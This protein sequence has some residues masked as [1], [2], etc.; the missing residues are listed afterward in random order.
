MTLYRKDIEPAGADIRQ[1]SESS[2][3]NTHDSVCSNEI[4]PSMPQWLGQSINEQ[5]HALAL[6]A[7]N[8][9]LWDWNLETDEVHY[10]PRWK[11]MLGYAEDE[12]GNTISVWDELV[13]PEDKDRVLKHV[14]DY[15]S[16]KSES[17]DIEMRMMHKDGRVIDI[18]SRAYSALS[19]TSGKPTRLVGTH[20][21][22]T[23]RVK[24][25]SFSRRTVEILEMIALG[26]P[27]SEIYDAIGLMYEDRHPGLRCS[28][29]EL[30]NGVLLHGGAPSMPKEYCDAVHGLKNGPEVGSC[31]T[32]T[33]WG[34]RC[35]VENIETDPK[36]ADIKQYAL[37]HGMRSCWSEPI[38]NSNGVVLGAFGMY[39][40]YPALPNEDESDDLT[41]AARL[42]GIIMERDHHQ[43]QIHDLAFTDQLTGLASRAHFYNYLGD[44]ITTS[45]RHGRSFSLIYVDLDSFKDVNDSLGHDSGDTLLKIIADRLTDLGGEVD[46]ISRLSGDEFCIVAENVANTYVSA[47][48]AQQCIEVISQPAMVAGRML[49]STCSAGIS[50]F[51]ADGESTSSLIKA[52][53]TALYS[54][55]YAGKN[56]YA[57]YEP[58]LTELAE[59]RFKFEQFL[60]EAIDN[61][62]MSLVYQPQ[63]ETSTGEIIGVEALCRWNHP[64][65]GQVSP[66]EFIEAAERIGM[67]KPLTEW[68]LKT[69][70][71]QAV[72][73]KH[74]GLPD[75]RVAVNISPS[76]FLD[77]GLIALVERMIKE[78][79][80]D[81]SQLELEVTESV[82]QTDQENLSVFNELD[83]LGILIAIDDFGTGYSSFSSLK[84]IEV[85]YLKIDK[86]FIDDIVHDEK[87]KLLVASMI[88]IGHN[89]GHRIIAEGVEDSSQL[90]LLDEMGCD[91]IQGYLF[92][93]PIDAESLLNLLKSGVVELP[94][95]MVA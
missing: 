8:D 1:Q 10:S 82:V 20:V 68:V 11:S 7:A 21:D 63:V 83:N 14:E 91:T 84:H 73:W 29:L 85:D 18:W 67:I 54:A 48:I 62:Q 57:F 43:K 3:S 71:N 50:H 41:S 74:Q 59:Y 28:M 78:T 45:K 77:K 46:F 66:I 27:A 49:T 72:N 23:E 51:P 87:T 47:K 61:E 4:A 9:G 37:P 36:W 16:N 55:K 58:K 39:H 93:K 24:A 34:K 60:R 5:R 53:D 12:L 69:A 42:A 44:L 64:V 19:E 22:I 35:I 26:N 38:I 32:S 95:K 6:R 70:C 17:F 25:E 13:H 81:P 33:Y 65:L 30:E 15:L 52:A 90:N 80:I 89:L 79:G 31:G 2:I 76:H 92:S 88:D 86:Y 56:R 94:E 40:D 75:L